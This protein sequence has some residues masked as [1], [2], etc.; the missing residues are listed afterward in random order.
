VDKDIRA[1]IAPNKAIS[2]D[3]TEPFH[4]A[5]HTVSATKGP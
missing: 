3:I 5:N 4:F 2:P 1:V